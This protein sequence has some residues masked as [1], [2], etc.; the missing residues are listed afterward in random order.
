MQPTTRQEVA[1][2][3]DQVRIETSS[4]KNSIYLLHEKAV[5]LLSRA[6]AFEHGRRATLDHVQNILVQLRVSLIIEDP[7]AEGLSFIYDHCYRLLESEDGRAMQSAHRM[8]FALKQVF[9][10]LLSRP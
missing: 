8:L 9:R 5:H 7:V 6:L 10:I 4:L 2:Y 3:Y 1:E